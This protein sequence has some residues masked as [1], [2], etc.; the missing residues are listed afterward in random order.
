M[1][2]ARNAEGMEWRA[3]AVALVALTAGCGAFAG[4]G[5]PTESITPAPVPTPP[6]TP[7]DPRVGVAPGLDGSG[8]FDREYLAQS[9]ARMALSTRYVWTERDL[10]QREYENVSANT[11]R[12]QRV[13]YVDQTT[14]HREVPYF[15]TRTDGRLL[16][17]QDYEEYA[18]GDVEYRKWVVPAEGGNTYDRV[19]RPNSGRD[20]AHFAAGAILKYLDLE[21]ESVSRVDVGDRP[22][23][24]VEGTRS[25]MREHGEVADYRARAV[26]R[27]DGFVRSLEVR[28]N[29]TNGDERVAARY[30]FTYSEVGSAS[31]EEPDWVTE[32][33][34]EF[35]DASSRM[36]SDRA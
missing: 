15:E 12:S 22:H 28:Y 7:E 20:Y 27:D 16:F 9:H 1:T 23:Y 11:S 36:E 18:D 2:L 14:Y 29:T 4:T 25:T 31:V 24:R 17:L 5:E 26:I 8:I 33:R 21:N 32:A 30:N 10:A 34:A 3:V 13:T 35:G 19:Q 6:P